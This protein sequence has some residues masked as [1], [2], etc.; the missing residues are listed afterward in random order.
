[1]SSHGKG[2][3]QLTLDRYRPC[4]YDAE[5]G[6]W[7]PITGGASA[8]LGTLSS[9]MVG[10]ADLP[11]EIVLGLKATVQQKAAERA[12]KASSPSSPASASDLTLSK[13]STSET[14]AS[15]ASNETSPTTISSG[16][17]SEDVASQEEK[18]F[19]PSLIT[20]EKRAHT[21]AI[22]TMLKPRHTHRLDPGDRAS[23]KAAVHAEQGLT[24]IASAVLRPPMDITMSIARGFHNAPKLYGD[25]TVRSSDKIVNFKTGITAAGREFGLGFYDGISGLLTQPFNGAKKRGVKGFL[26]GIGKGVSGL[27][28]KPGA[29]KI[30]IIL[31]L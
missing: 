6:P 11:V 30:D 9:L 26:E 1:M 10:I 17:S 21:I 14:I 15:N 12:S 7:D 3:T 8:L 27:I 13:Q 22:D 20:P 5:D 25:D 2:F 24:S 19:E 31:T 29:G 16:R 28:L 18:Q 23:H 4:E